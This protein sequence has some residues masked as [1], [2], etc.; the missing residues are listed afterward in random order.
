M[1][2]E[3]LIRQFEV[4]HM[5][6]LALPTRLKYASLLRCHVRPA[7]SS[8]EIEELTTRRLDEWLASKTADKLS[9]ETR[10]SLRN[11]ICGIFTRAEIWET[12]EGRNPTKRV[13]VGRKKPAREKRKMSIADSRKLLNMFPDDFR[14]ICMVAL[15]C[16]LRISEVLGLTWRHV[17]FSRGMLLIRQR[18]YRGDVDVPK[19]DKARRDIP[20][21]HLVEWLR[22]LYPGPQAAN[23]YCFSVRTIH[24]F[25]RDDA[26]MRRYFLRP[27]AEKLGLYYPGFGFHSFRREAVTAISSKIGAIQACRVAGHSRMDT[28]LLYGL[29]DYLLQET[30]IKSMQEPFRGVMGV[31]GGLR[32]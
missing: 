30:A 31:R 18:Y 3:D 9:W 15:F 19:C 23:D 8:L 7:L 28:T 16:G 10:N 14:V 29:D 32:N 4:A 11:L 17:D 5:P 21:G 22:A 24:G 26:T 20:F 25:T 2:F 1:L 13:T 6:N 27:P 12:Y